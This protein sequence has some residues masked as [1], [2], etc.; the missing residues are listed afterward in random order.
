[1]SVY[2]IGSLL[3]CI[4][5]PCLCVCINP[6]LWLWVWYACGGVVLWLSAWKCVNKHF[7]CL[8]QSLCYI[9]Q[10]GS[11]CV[12]ISTCLCLSVI[13]LV[14]LCKPVCSCLYYYVCVCIYSPGSV[15]GI[16]HV[17]DSWRS[18]VSLIMEKTT[19]CLF[20][21]TSVWKEGVSEACFLLLSLF[22]CMCYQI[23]LTPCLKSVSS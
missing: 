18:Q 7:V 23:L 19:Y 20:L 3:R 2:K 13:L 17:C 16:V 11:F 1:M 8:R 12:F 9:P 21:C 22:L 10:Y 15:F 5:S 6:G 4:T 14:F